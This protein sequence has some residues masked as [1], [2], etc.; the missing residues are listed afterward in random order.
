MYLESLATIDAILLDK[1]GTL[2]YGTPEVGDGRTVD[3]VPVGSLLQAAATAEFRVRA[4][5]REG[6]SEEGVKPGNLR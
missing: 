3:G 1:T 6:N 2:T 4:S 5:G